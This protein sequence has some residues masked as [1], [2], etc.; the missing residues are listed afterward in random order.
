MQL[1]RTLSFLISLSTNLLLH[2][3]VYSLQDI[4]PTRKYG[5]TVGGQYSSQTLTENSHQQQQWISKQIQRGLL[6]EEDQAMMVYGSD[7]SITDIQLNSRAMAVIGLDEREQVQNTTM[8]PY[9]TIGK[10][11]VILPDESTRHCT[12]TYI[13]QNLV[14]TA[15]HCIYAL[16]NPDDVNVLDIKFTTVYNESYRPK[17]VVSPEA[18]LYGFFKGQPI[19]QFGQYDLAVLVLDGDE[20]PQ[21]E[22]TMSYGFQGCQEGD[23]ILFIV[24]YPGDKDNGKNMYQSFCNA[25]VNTCANSTVFKHDCDTSSGM[26]GSTIWSSDLY[27][28]KVEII[29][30]H[31]RHQ[32]IQ[33]IGVLLNV[34]A[35]NFLTNM[36]NFLD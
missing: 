9:N 5:G 6:Q 35:M 8:F 19:E 15:A 22:N 12:G 2:R 28:H 4:V 34:E 7:V 1:T 10:V 17:K 25:Y 20:F 16:N 29:G 33:N 3:Q 36:D 11:E 32:Y 24:G 23:R 13:G 18:F 30:V 21:P 14:L 27:T 31:S 26:S